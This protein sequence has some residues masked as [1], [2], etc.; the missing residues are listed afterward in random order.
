MQRVFGKRILLLGLFLALA[1]VAAACGGDDNGD[2][3]GTDQ[4]AQGEEL[5]V[6]RFSGL[7]G[8]TSSLALK[9]I[10]ENGFDVANGFEGEYSYQEADAANQ[11][12]YQGRSEVAFDIDVIGVAIARAQGIDITSIGSVVTNHICL[13]TTEDSPIESPEELAGMKVGHYGTDSGGTVTLSIL[14]DELYGIDIFKDWE[15]VESDPNGIIALLNRGNLDATVAFQPNIARENLERG[16]DCMTPYF[17]EMWNELYGGHLLISTIAAHDEW[18]EENPDLAQ[19]VL[20]A[21]DE[22]QA[23]LSDNPEALTESPYKELTG[24]ED[25][26]VLERFAGYVNSIPMY[27]STWDEDVVAAQEAFIDL[28]AEQGVLLEENPGGVTT[29]LGE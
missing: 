22:G 11:F 26:E 14:M 21:W 24:V 17:T 29:I 20:D 10:E 19:A 12:F 28:A 23:W 18:I 2:A 7:S 15:M 6:I 5:P 4:G 9:V 25:P 8:G 27:L 1:L 3:E 13:M 16:S